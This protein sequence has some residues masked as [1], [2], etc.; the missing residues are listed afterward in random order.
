MKSK[1]EQTA[2]VTFNIEDHDVTTLSISFRNLDCWSKLGQARE[3]HE[4]S[5]YDNAFKE[6]FEL[7]ASNVFAIKT[8]GRPDGCI[9]WKGKNYKH[10]Q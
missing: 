2:F 9:L 4:M 3:Q 1:L 7:F 6:S 8:W 5:C 10:R